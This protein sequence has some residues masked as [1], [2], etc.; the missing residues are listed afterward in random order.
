MNKKL[1]YLGLLASI[2]LL[3]ALTLTL[4]RIFTDSPPNNTTDEV[5]V[6]PENEPVVALQ[7]A[8]TV[9]TASASPTA[10]SEFNQ[11]TVTASPANSPTPEVKPKQAPE[12]VFNMPTPPVR[13]KL[14]LDDYS[15]SKPEVILSDTN[16]II[17]V[18]WLPAGQEILINRL[19][20]GYE[21]IDTFNMKSSELRTYAER[22]SYVGGI[23]WLPALSAVVY[24]SGLGNQQELRISDGKKE[25]TQT[26]FS[27]QFA[28]FSRAS[29]KGEQLIY[30]VESE[31]HRLDT[32]TKATE[33]LGIELSQW[34][35]PHT[36]RPLNYHRTYQI[37]PN[38]TTSQIAVYKS[39]YFFLVDSKTK[40][41]CEIE[42]ERPGDVINAQWSSNGQ[43]LAVNRHVDRSSE[44]LLLDSTSG[45]FKKI[46]LASSLF[47][48]K[49]MPNDDKLVVLV[50]ESEELG[51]IG[52]L[53]LID[54]RTGKSRQMLPDFFFI[55]ARGLADSIV[56]DSAQ[57]RVVTQCPLLP[58]DTR[59]IEHRL[60]LIYVNQQS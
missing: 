39:S 45:Q 16:P 55:G 7:K 9:D 60:C 53:Y 52:T 4:G 58:D 35:Y 8:T 27:K 3:I 23:S 28:S 59:S 48:M 5:L 41:V 34:E 30:L 54:A 49:W 2:I 56:I 33:S 38:P 6:P 29:Q 51:A 43:Y 1:T 20:K 17:L 19:Y 46:E 13:Q 24:H 10:F 21:T 26:L 50:E 32:L 40:E 22:G 12:C 25:Q 42:Q 11:P 47:D 44:L 18:E 36:I 15:F 14:S 57:M 31:L 37:V